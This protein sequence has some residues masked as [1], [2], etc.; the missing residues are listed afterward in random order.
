MSD[1]RTLLQKVHDAYYAA[2]ANGYDLDREPAD[3]VA[4]DMK[5]CDAE[6]EKENYSSILECVKQIQSRRLIRG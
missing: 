6:L 5:D 4:S 3:W 1:E 2:L